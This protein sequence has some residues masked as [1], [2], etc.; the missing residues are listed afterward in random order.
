MNAVLHASPRRTARRPRDTC[1]ADPCPSYQPPKWNGVNTTPRATL[2]VTMALILIFAPSGPSSQ[3]HW[4]SLMPALLA[5]AGLIS[6]NMSCCSS[7]SHGLERVSSPPPSYSTRRPL[8][9]ISG[10]SLSKSWPG[11]SV[12]GRQPVE[13]LAVLVGRDT[14]PRGRVARCRAARD[15]SAPDPG[16]SRRHACLGVAERRSNRA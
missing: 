9:W 8:V 10:K 12:A 5:S 11:S 15:G 13:A 16:R 7:A 14:S 6:A 4:P 2:R 1:P 3:I